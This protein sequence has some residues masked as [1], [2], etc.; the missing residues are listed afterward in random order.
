MGIKLKEAR[1]P[2]YLKL[3]FYGLAGSGKTYTA[4]Q[5]LAQFIKEYAPEL[6][7]ALFDTEGGAGFIAPMVQKITGKP[8]MSIAATS[9]SELKEF[10]ELC[11]GKYVGL[12]DSA[13]HPWRTLCED[14]LEAKRS[15]INGAGGNTK[16]VRLALPDWGP[17][18]SIWNQGFS[19]PFKFLPA[20]LCYC[21]RAGDVWETKQDEEGKDKIQSTGTKINEE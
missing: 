20:H 18:K 8:L 5:V 15:R 10:L 12:I 3:A 17:I 14:F 6:Q 13:T 1:P 11:P 7:L 2:Q 16:N 21:G 9:F 4:A 19:D